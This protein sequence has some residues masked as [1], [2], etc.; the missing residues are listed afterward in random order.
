MTVSGATLPAQATD[1]RSEA[2]VRAFSDLL[3]QKRVLDELA[4]RRAERAQRQSGERFDVVL[5]RLGLVPEGILSAAL[6][7]YFGIDVAAPQSFPAAPLFAGELQVPFLKA[8]K[9]LPLA[10]EGEGV[11]VAVADP[12]TRE[13]ADA[14]AYLLGRPVSI[15]LAGEAEI[16]NAIT[17]LYERPGGSPAAGHG[18]EGDSTGQAQDED[19]RQLADLGSEAPVI[20]LV[21]ELISR[22]AEMGA[23]DIHI[24]PRED[25]LAV[26]FRI[27]GIL[28]TVEQLS[29]AL[30]PAVTSRI[31]IMARLN[32]AEQRL[33]QDGRI[34]T[35]VRGRELDLRIS[36]MPT[37]KGE[38]VVLRLL[39]RASVALDFAALGFAGAA[40]EGLEKVLSEPNG[41]VLVTGPTGS[42]KTTT[43][44]AA[45]Q[46]LNDHRIKIFTVEDPVEYQITGLNQIQVQPKI[47]LTF[48]SA[49]RSI[50]RQDPDVILVGEMRDLETAEVAIQASLTGHLVLS[51]VHTNSAAA[52]ITR[53][54]DMGVEPFL[55]A[56]CLKA[57]L[58]QR[59][60]RKLCASCAAPLDPGSATGVRLAELAEKMRPSGVAPVSLA[61]CRI[62]CGCSQCR[63]T[64]FA[65][66]TT[67][68]E[69]LPVSEPVRRAILARAG[70]TEIIA[71]ARAGG[72]TSMFEDGLG[73]VLGG[74][75]TLD[76]VMRSVRME[77]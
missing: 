29:V 56:S 42:G 9:I 17:Q 14:L 25:C 66:R 53:L 77:V 33:P 52:T 44:Y 36:T 13:A 68:A 6:A 4:L 59:L 15:R 71:A 23:S 61:A 48:A 58:A 38:S 43:L 64:G 60:V 70:E 35:T 20:R 22:A 27:D 12:S 67:I 2:F 39:D 8:N 28:Q 7:D 51:T 31:K 73:K 16:A 37:L 46:T 75:T 47:A 55:I 54:L 34:R 1:M 65:G 21:N 19:V 30:R 26:R 10:V 50:L 63:N 40:R 11:V 32:I 76:E 72:M 49:L 74:E 57:I 3:V 45:L 5:S 62:A 41:I 69:L 18:A 24:E